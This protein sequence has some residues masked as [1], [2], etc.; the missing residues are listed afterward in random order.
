MEETGQPAILAAQDKFPPC[1]GL[2]KIT[3]N[4]FGTSY[5]GATFSLNSLP[6]EKAGT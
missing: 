1:F 2:P 6:A 5:L 4:F 3:L